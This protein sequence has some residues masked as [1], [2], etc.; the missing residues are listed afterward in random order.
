M[1]VKLESIVTRNSMKQSLLYNIYFPIY[2]PILHSIYSAN[3]GFMFNQPHIGYA[4][5][6]NVTHWLKL[7]L[8]IY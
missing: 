2:N 7:T 6:I 1:W 5:M 4:C 8:Q 3:A